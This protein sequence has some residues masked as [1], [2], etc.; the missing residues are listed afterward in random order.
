MEKYIYDNSSGGCVVA[1]GY[2]LATEFLKTLR[3][4]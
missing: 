3:I 4:A 2:K 1:S